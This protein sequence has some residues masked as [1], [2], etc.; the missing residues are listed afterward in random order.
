MRIVIKLGGSV[1]TYKER[2]DF[3]ESTT[4][5]KLKGNEYIRHDSLKHIIKEI[6]KAESVGKHQ[7]I[8]VNGAGPFGHVLVQNKLN[9]KDIK[10]EFIHESVKFLNKDITDEFKTAG[11]NIETLHPFELCSCTGDGAFDVNELCEKAAR[12]LKKGIIPS[13]YGDVVPTSNHKGRLGDYEVLSGD[14]LVYELAKYLKADKVIIVSD[15]DGVYDKNPKLFSDA[16]FIRTI[17]DGKFNIQNDTITVDVTG[18]L[19]GK[20]NLLAKL[21]VEN[22]IK[23]QI[24]NGL[25]PGI[26]GMALNGDES[27][28]TLIK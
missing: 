25:I 24:I 12:L 8:L 21:S 27:T 4:E 14:V 3:P 20:L 23:S 5:L 16:H 6:T 13:T 18:S 10:T 7:F 19:R 11:I 2:T 22:R 28:G 17:K 9:G 15:V 26:L 1:A